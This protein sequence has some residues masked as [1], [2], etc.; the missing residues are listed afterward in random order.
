MLEKKLGC[1]L[2]AK[3]REILLME[4]DCNH[5][6]KEIFGQ[7]MLNNVRKHG[8]VPEEI[9]SK[10]GKVPD[11]GTL[12]KVIFYDLV[13]QTRLSAGVSSVDAANCYDSVAHAIAS[14]TCQAFGVPA[15]AVQSM[16]TTIEN[17]KYYLRTAYGD[18]KN[19]RGHKI[20]VKFQGLCQGNGAA[21]AGWAVISIV[22]LGAHKRKG[23]GGHFV[24]PI[25]CLTGHLSA[26]LFVDNNDLIHIDMGKDQSAEEAAYDLQSSIDS[27]GHLLIASGGSLK[28][29]KCFFYLISFVWKADRK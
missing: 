9:Y 4:A 17:M 29:E 20:A 24:C 15:E 28:P 21:P 8:L 12:A 13:R 5:S 6:N 18:S 23:H 1:T 25:S 26:I 19:F 3:L 11:D 27:W 7:R 22:I 2:L 16:L 14:L 10:R